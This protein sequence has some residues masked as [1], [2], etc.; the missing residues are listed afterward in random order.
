ML[1]IKQLF[2]WFCSYDKIEPSNLQLL[3]TSM[4][5]IEYTK[6]QLNSKI[7]FHVIFPVTAP[8]LER[9]SRQFLK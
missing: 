7:I 9:Q 3:G 5:I 2:V 6:Y 8:Y 1:E 4:S